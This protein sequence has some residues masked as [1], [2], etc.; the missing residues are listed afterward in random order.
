M[1]ATSARIEVTRVDESG[2][3]A[4]GHA[5]YLFVP[6]LQV[7]KPRGMADTAAETYTVHFIACAGGSIQQRISDVMRHRASV[8]LRA[9]SV[10]RYPVSLVTHDRRLREL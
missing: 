2:H 7:L 3:T 8:E 5:G 6:E 10:E 1:N 9:A 4:T